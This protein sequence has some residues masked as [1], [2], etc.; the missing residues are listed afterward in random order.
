MVA[1]DAVAAAPMMDW[2]MS[3]SSGQAIIGWGQYECILHSGR[4]VSMSHYLTAAP[5][6]TKGSCK[7][8]LAQGSARKGFNVS[9]STSLPKSP[10][11]IAGIKKPRTM[12]RLGVLIGQTQ[13][14]QPTLNI[15][16]ICSLKCKHVMT[17]FCN[18]PHA[19]AIVK[20]ILQRLV[21]AEERRVDNL[22][23]FPADG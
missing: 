13:I 20:R 3:P 9:C 19:F 12:A 5:S 21:Q 2:I 4:S 10:D 6:P 22:L 7:S 18:F 15:L 16:L 17:I 8:N 1:C 11:R 14:R 23:N